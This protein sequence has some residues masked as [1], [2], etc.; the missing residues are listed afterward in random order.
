MISVYQAQFISKTTPERGSELDEAI[1]QVGRG[2][3]E[4]I[5]EVFN[6]K[7]S[8]EYV[9]IHV[10]DVDTDDL[11][12]AFEKTNTIDMYWWDNPEV[13]AYKTNT[14]STSVGDILVQGGVVKVV[15][16]MG[17]KNLNITE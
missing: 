10:A 3:L 12:I 9:Y 14:R 6:E 7:Y 2:N 5:K 13:K 16:D 4:V 1:W 11:E 8:G 15:A 17:F